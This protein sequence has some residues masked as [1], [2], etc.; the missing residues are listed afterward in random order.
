MP[1]VATDTPLKISPPSVP[2]LRAAESEAAQ[3]MRCPLF[4]RATQTVWGEGPAHARIMM[5]GEQPGDR[6]DREGEPFVGPAGALLDRGL[7]AAGIDRKE[8]YLTN[9]VK[10]FKWVPAQRRRLHQKPNA[11]EIRACRHWLETEL[12]L[13]APDVV[14][15]LGATAAESMMGP[16]F[17]ITESHGQIW[18]TPWSH[19]FIATFH[20]AA[21]LR[22][23]SDQRDQM[24]E[25]FVADL[26]V[27][28]HALRH[29]PHHHR[30]SA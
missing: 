18:E 9:A 8:V 1:H 10:H 22:T 7:A 13:V 4:M 26:K 5:V 23:P 30:A 20:P 27:A 28:A 6:E 17:R 16:I 3:C 11:R 15:A 24:F 12:A 21:L 29:A 2:S 25:D 19:A 14:V